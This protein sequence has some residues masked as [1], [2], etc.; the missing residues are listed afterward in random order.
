M[1]KNFLKN[2][3]E[4]SDEGYL[5]EADVQ[6]LEKLHELHNDLPVLLERMKIEKIEKLVDNFHDKTEYVMHKIN[7]KQTL[8]HGLVLGKNHKK[9]NL[10]KMRGSN[11]ILM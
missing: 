10:V 4:K 1:S 11:H 5:L 6:Y 8:N 7:L 3:N 2:Y 9:L